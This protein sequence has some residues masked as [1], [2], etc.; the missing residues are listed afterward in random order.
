MLND[1]GNTTKK[2]TKI[3]H[4]YIT[5]FASLKQF[6]CAKKMVETFMQEQLKNYSNENN[7]FNA[8]QSTIRLSHSFVTFLLHN[9]DQFMKRKIIKYYSSN[10]FRL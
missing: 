5:S 4:Y 8:W 10:I 9:C 2:I 7:R 1:T 3:I 6:Q